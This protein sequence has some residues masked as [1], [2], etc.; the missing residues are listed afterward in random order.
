MRSRFYLF[1]GI[2][3]LSTLTSFAQSVTNIDAS[4]DN[5]TGA[6]HVSYDLN[7]RS[8]NK[9]YKVEVHCS[10]DGGATYSE[11]LIGV[12]GDVG[13]NVRPG[14]GKK[15]NWA[16]FVDAPE[17]KGKNVVIKIVAKDDIEY[18]ENMTLSLG[19]PEKFYQ[20]ILVPGY[21]N[22]HVRKGKRYFLITTA[23]AG[24]IGGGIYLKYKADNRYSD[25]L[26]S[27]TPEQASSHYDKASSMAKMSN[28]LLMSG[29]AIWS[30]DV[31]QVITKGLVNR[32]KQREILRRR[33]K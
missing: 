18:K 1:V 2:L 24:L 14:A 16:Y 21:G 20:S 12:S 27:T 31:G 17:F 15:I 32:K 3:L 7:A 13:Y 10:E 5:V 11:A 4:M 28:A 6:V 8:N 23:V 33:Q 30:I 25:Y 26:S 19:G 22:Y 9:R 29:A